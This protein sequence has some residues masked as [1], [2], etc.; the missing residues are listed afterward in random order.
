MMMATWVIAGLDV[1]WGWTA[2]WPL[3]AHLAGL[4]FNVL[5]YSLFM[6]AMTANAFFSEG[7][8]IQTER[9]HTVATGGPY[10]FVR[11]PGYLG[12]ITANLAT[13]VLLGSWWALLPAVALAALYILR[14]ALE[15]RT[16][17]AE[18]PGY[19]EFTQQTRFRLFPGV[20]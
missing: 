6:W 14:T 10:R 5:G 16:L 20:W 1:R 19:K 7:V 15:D 8:R 4:L 18:L 12:A 2:S 13:P 3:A 9:G 11:H 17:Q